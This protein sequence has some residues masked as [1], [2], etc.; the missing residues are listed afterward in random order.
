[1]IL[2][3]FIAGLIALVIVL[4]TLPAFGG[5]VECDISIGFDSPYF[6][7]SGAAFVL[8]TGLLAGSYP[9]FFLS[10]FNPVNVLKGTFR[11]VNAVFNPRK[12]LVVIQFSIAIILIIGTVVLHRQ[13]QYGK[14]RENGYNKNNL[15][16]IFEMGEVT[17]NSSLIKNDLLSNGIAE[18]VTRTSSP[19]TEG[20][21]NSWGFEWQGKQPDD[22]TVFDRFC[23]DE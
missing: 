10:A 3:A 6:W 13:I 11:R 4:A 1:S 8:L 15:V 9:A 19:L 16:Y 18:S 17:K 12:I 14:D 7:L 23:V 5:L 2:L 22:K 20:W 21:S